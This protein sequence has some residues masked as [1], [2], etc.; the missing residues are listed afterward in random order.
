M[1][2]TYLLGVVRV[3]LPSILVK[4]CIRDPLRDER[5]TGTFCRG[6]IDAMDVQSVLDKL[7]QTV[8]ELQESNSLGQ[9]PF[10]DHAV[11]TNLP[12][13]VLKQLHNLAPREECIIELVQ[14]NL[15]DDTSSDGYVY[16]LSERNGLEH[17]EN[18]MRIPKP[19]S[20]ALFAI[21]LQQDVAEALDRLTAF[22]GIIHDLQL[23]IWPTYVAP[24]LQS[25]VVQYLNHIYAV[26]SY[27]TGDNQSTRQAVDVCTVRALEGRAPAANRTDRDQVH[28]AFQM[29]KAFSAVTS[30]QIRAAMLQKASGLL[31][32]I[33][34]MRSFH[35]NLDY[36]LIADRIIRSH[37]FPTESIESIWHADRSL[38]STLREYWVPSTPYVEIWEGR[39]QQARGLAD[40]HLAYN[41]LVLA[42]LRQFPYLDGASPTLASD[43]TW[44]T[45]LNPACA[46][47]FQRRAYLLGFQTDHLTSE[48][49]QDVPTS[50]LSGS[51]ELSDESNLAGSCD[52]R[53]GIPSI[54]AFRFIQQ[55]AFL[56]R[57]ARSDG[58]S[59][60]MTAT[61]ALNDFL[62]IYLNNCSFKFDMCGTQVRLDGPAGSQQPSI[63]NS[64]LL[65]IELQDA[66]T[67][68]L[69]DSHLYVLFPVAATTHEDRNRQR[70]LEKCGRHRTRRPIN[71]KA[72]VFL[73]HCSRPVS[74][75]SLQPSSSAKQLS[76]TAKTIPI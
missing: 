19:S 43:E 62:Q 29:N 3:S 69:P 46:R 53:W 61:F 20:E 70:R 5:L 52:Y 37:L 7:G 2:K 32:V 8:S 60:E 65:D 41:Q 18:T 26:W 13:Q 72:D 10:L 76:M 63:I 66:A 9:Q 11:W 14:T 67:N 58:Y 28:Q 44:A 33:P 75:R 48:V 45:S 68:F 51:W 39:F 35:G 64:P 56:P 73:C 34:S 47:L 1:D 24:S 59:T 6:F 25:E 4:P 16:T 42:A 74:K 38:A 50:V 27:I 49:L 40:F 57:L 31:I 36:L 55:S 54:R 17:A 71:R 23:R 30:P 15:H 21:H 22:P 12:R